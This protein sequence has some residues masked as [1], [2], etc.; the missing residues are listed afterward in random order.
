MTK[1][2]TTD[3]ENATK[4]SYRA[5]YH[6]T[7]TGEANAITETLIKMYAVHMAQCML[8]EQPKKEDKTMRS[9]KPTSF[10]HYLFVLQ[11][12]H[13]SHHGTILSVSLHQCFPTRVPQN[14][15]R[16]S[17]RNQRKNPDFIMTHCFLQQKVLVSKTIG[18]DLKQDLDV[19]VN[20]VSFIKQRP[21]KSRVFAKL[22]E[23][24]QKDHVTLLQH[25][26]V[27]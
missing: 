2:A 25:T 1:V 8:D 21:L 11:H 10:L 19:A 6:I 9:Y 12:S 17:T 7:L 22:S 5:S 24:M 4:A 14:I 20:T 23:N 3:N 13:F 27:R 18:E 16:G 15:I 26:E